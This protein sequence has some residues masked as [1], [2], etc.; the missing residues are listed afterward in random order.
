[1]AGLTLNPHARIGTADPPSTGLVVTVPQPGA[2]L[3]SVEV[4]E[5]APEYPAVSRL[6]SA[7]QAGS[8]KIPG[9][10]LAHLRAL[11]IIAERAAITPLPKLRIVLRAPA[12]ATSAPVD[13]ELRGALSDADPSALH[14][15][16]RM[17]LE[18]G[19]RF[20]HTPPHGSGPLPWWPADER[21]EAALRQLMRERR[22][23]VS[24]GVAEAL[25]AAWIVDSPQHD[26][27]E[28]EIVAARSDLERYDYARLRTLPPALL[29]DVTRYYGALI[30]GGFLV[31]KDSALRYWAHNDLVGRM[32]HDYTLAAVEQAVGKRL[33]SSYSYFS[34][35]R[36][37]ALLVDH[38]D[39]EQCE[40][41]VNVVLDYR[42]APNGVVDWPLVLQAGEDVVELRSRIG[43]SVIFRGGIL[44][45]RRPTLAPEH[46]CDIIL[47]HFVDES[48][49]GPLG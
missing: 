31:Y 18:A 45:H 19:T 4:D 35:Y 39:R 14:K 42:P 2:G 20:W 43:D 44:M 13:V 48:F 25:A 28:R 49:E 3:V 8:T 12:G 32:L 9:G 47:F 30:E 21:V 10:D 37:E 40:L 11:G 16:V 29:A 15:T 46:E 41:T 34:G 33:K 22:A 5:T 27:V 7:L 1:M 6:L 24:R 23:S 36:N 17:S 38:L 26:A